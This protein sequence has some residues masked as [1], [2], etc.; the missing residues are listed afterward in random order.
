[1]RYTYRR[2]RP[3][4]ETA[5]N[6]LYE[7]ITGFSRTV[8]EYRWQWLDAPGGEGEI[9][10]IEAIK[11]SGETQ[12]IG[13]HGLM[14]IRFTFG[15]DDLLFGK[16]E[17][18][19]VLPEYRRKI[20]YPKY[21]KIFLSE[22][23]VRFD[24]IFS[25]LGPRAA[26]RQ[27]QALGYN[28]DAKWCHYEHELRFLGEMTKICRKLPVPIAK[29]LSLLISKLPSYSKKTVIN[30]FRELDSDNARVDPFFESFWINARLT[31]GIAPRRDKEDLTWRFWNNPYND[32]CTLVL[33][34]NETISGYF[35]INVTDPNIFHIEDVYFTPLDAELWQSAFR[36]L[37]DWASEKGA[38]LIKYKTTNDGLLPDIQK[39]INTLCKPGP[40]TSWIRKNRKIPE[41]SMLRKI[42][43]YSKYNIDLSTNNWNITPILFEGRR[44]NP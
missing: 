7:Q 6:N 11:D 19:M 3:G 30:Q 42:S 36:L 43:N 38:S 1:M 31:A 28:A 39:R 27:R 5:I 2:F 34:N 37:F 25:T 21:E 10:L 17:N 23:E 13:H 15:S 40:L 4:D 24:A 41:Q 33:D 29:L 26:L 14:P 9:W 22:Y 12:L 32:Y 8:D 18:T 16:T 44:N 35:I 20:L